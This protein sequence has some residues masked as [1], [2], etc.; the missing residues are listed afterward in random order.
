MPTL[1]YSGYFGTN[2]GG[3]SNV[4]TSSD[5]LTTCYSDTWEGLPSGAIVTKVSYSFTIDSDKANSGYEHRL[6]WISV[7]SYGSG[8]PSLYASGSYSKDQRKYATMNSASYTFTGDMQY[9]VSGSEGWFSDYYI[10]VCGKGNNSSSGIASKMGDISITVTYELPQWNYSPSN[11]SISQ[12]ND[13]TFKISWNAASWSGGS[14]Y[15]KYYIYCPQ[16][17]T[18][19]YF[20]IIGETSKKYTIPGY[21]TDYTFYISAYEN[22]T[23][24]WA[25]DSIEKTYNFTAPYVTAP[26][27]SISPT[28]GISTTITRTNSSLKYTD[29]E[30]TYNLYRNNILVGT[31]SDLT[32]TIS[33]DTLDS[34]NS[35]NIEF[36]VKVTTS[37][38][39]NNYGSPLTNKSNTVT[40]KYNLNKTILYYTGNGSINGYEECIVYYY[41]GNLNEGDN[42]WVECE[43]YIYTGESN[44]TIN[45]WQLCSYT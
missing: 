45:G 2:A 28:S 24:S 31:F 9:Y 37:N 35:E 30:I 25:G 20:D 26:T 17:S 3:T 5:N 33:Q 34:W 7:G 29:G 27:I 19:N 12:N 14:S 22:Q 21:S 36:Q 10:T 41:T 16:I 1:T 23:G 18:D 44:A 15:I 38:L 32:Y 6:Y 39:T 40:F 11:I 43:P 13:G 42:G 4:P 8:G